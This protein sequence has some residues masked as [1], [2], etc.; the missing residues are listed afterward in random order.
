MEMLRTMLD[1]NGVG[2]VISNMAAMKGDGSQLRGNLEVRF[3]TPVG[4]PYATP[5]SGH[6]FAPNVNTGS[7]THGMLPI[8]FYHASCTQYQSYTVA[9]NSH[10]E[11]LW[12]EC[13]NGWCCRRLGD[14]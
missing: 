5:N 10:G 2:E 8:P 6:S 9:N 13:T 14:Y 1:K 11:C 3:P 7:S 4:Q 12:H